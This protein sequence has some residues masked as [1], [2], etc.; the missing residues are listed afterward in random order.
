MD[1]TGLIH[2]VS[3]ANSR[4]VAY[5]IESGKSLIKMIKS[6][7]PRMLRVIGT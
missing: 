3:S 6:R 7:G 4:G 2:F 5:E 1:E